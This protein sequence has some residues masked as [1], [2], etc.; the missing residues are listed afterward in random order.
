MGEGV[1]GG[2]LPADYLLPRTVLLNGLQGVFR[3][4]PGL[5]SDGPLVIG[6]QVHIAEAHP[7]HRYR[8]EW[9]EVGAIFD[10]V[11]VNTTRA[12][13]W[14]GAMEQAKEIARTF[15]WKVLSVRRIGSP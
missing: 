10:A 13:N 1:P 11:H 3:Q 12:F 8:L 2:E 4:P 5:D 14:A 15:G 6:K 7:V 9:T